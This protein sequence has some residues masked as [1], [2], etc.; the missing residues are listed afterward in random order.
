MLK[1]FPK[2]QGVA[3]KL[4]IFLLVLLSAI[5]SLFYFFVGRHQGIAVDSE[6]WG[7]FGDFFGGV[8]NPIISL[9]NMYLLYRFFI[10]ES[11]ANSN[12]L[13]AEKNRHDSMLKEER[14]RHETALKEERERHKEIL[15][16]SVLALGDFRL[17]TVN[18]IQILFKNHGNGPLIITSIDYF[19]NEKKKIDELINIVPTPSFQYSIHSKVLPK[20]DTVI[21]S[22]DEEFVLFELNSSELSITNRHVLGY[23]DTWL[24]QLSQIEIVI[25]YKDVYENHEKKRCSLK[26][27]NEPAASFT[28]RYKIIQPV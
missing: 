10:I 28:S 11:S 2:I 3:P 13:K 23:F 25:E 9:V 6:P 1:K 8:L 18:K 21:L 14:S 5:L 17:S 24:F 15:R 16:N 4:I 12:A 7:Q 22:K 20:Y 27:W 26:Q 19:E